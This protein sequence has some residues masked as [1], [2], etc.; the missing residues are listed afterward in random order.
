MQRILQ[1][2]TAPQQQELP[3][4]Q[5]QQRLIVQ[6]KQQNLLMQL[7]QLTPEQIA[8]LPIEQQ[9]Q[10]LLLKQQVQGPRGY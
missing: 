5:E 3:D 9:N 8:V 1:T 10:I 7:M 4:Y 2:Q 6:E